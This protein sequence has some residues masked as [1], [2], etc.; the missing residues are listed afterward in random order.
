MTLD[1]PT[2]QLLLRMRNFPQESF[3]RGKKLLYA[4]HMLPRK[5]TKVGGLLAPLAKVE[6]S[7]EFRIFA[8]DLEA[9]TLS[10]LRD[11]SLGRKR[12]AYTFLAPVQ[13]N[14]GVG[15]DSGWFSRGNIRGK[16]TFFC[17]STRCCMFLANT[18]VCISLVVPGALSHTLFCE[19][20]WLREVSINFSSP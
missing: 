10:S 9:A 20:S 6:V 16:A 19:K 14:F 4:S 5:L 7:P 13:S 12:I 15:D 3:P 18:Y 1:K 11:C 17:S 8:W 2:A